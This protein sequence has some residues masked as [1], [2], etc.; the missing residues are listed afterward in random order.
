VADVVTALCAARMLRLAMSVDEALMAMISS[1]GR[2]YD[3]E[4]VVACV[5]LFRKRGFKL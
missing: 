1:A 3:A 4:E 2:L 5:R